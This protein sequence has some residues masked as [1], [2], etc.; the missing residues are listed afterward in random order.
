MIHASGHELRE[1]LQLVL[2]KTNQSA[3]KQRVHLFGHLSNWDENSHSVQALIP[4]HQNGDGDMMTS[5][6]IQF[7]TPVA[8]LSGDGFQ[9]V[10]VAGATADNLTGGEQ[11]LIDIVDT[12]N[13]MAVASCALFNPISF[14]PSYYLANGT[15]NP[16]PPTPGDQPMQRAEWLNR[17][18]TGTFWRFFQNGDYQAVGTGRV[19]LQQEAG[20]DTPGGKIEL[21]TN[22]D[23]NVTT[24][25]GLINI[26]ASAGIIN[27]TALAGEVHV[28]SPIINIGAL[29]ETLLPLLTAAFGVWATTHIHSGVTPGAGDSGPPVDPPPAAYPFETEAL[30]AG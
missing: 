19:I 25:V 7:G 27:I 13:G 24:P 9:Y 10:P 28:T 26:V 4:I 16:V 20:P 21:E 22:G 18:E 2:S 17:H 14:P 30:E 15:V 23:I 5:P 29:G 3:T 12:D 8:G 11:V 1:F 6:W